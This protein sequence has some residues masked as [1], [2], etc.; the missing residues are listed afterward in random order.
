MQRFDCA[1]LGV[2]AKLRIAPSNLYH[3]MTLILGIDPGSRVTGYGIIKATGER[4]EYVASGCIR[5]TDKTTLPEKLDEIFSG[6]SQIIDEYIP[7]ELAIE[8]IFVGRSAESAL[9]LGHARGVA[10]VAA[11]NKGVPIYEYEARKVKQA[12]VG[13]GAASKEQVQHMVQML[14]KLP[15]KPQ[16]DAADALAIAICHINT[17]QGLSRLAA[18]QSGKDN[19]P[20]SFSH[21]RLK[22]VEK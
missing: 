1:P 9:K 4:R 12:V 17:H 8:K 14:L 21:G 22:K 16:S 11:V 3:C 6:V 2:Y 19:A 15:G 20:N 18:S 7:D 5:T 10:I 13:T